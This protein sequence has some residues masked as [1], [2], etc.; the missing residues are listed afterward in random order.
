MNY[1]D[2]IIEREIVENEIK[3]IKQII[4]NESKYDLMSSQYKIEE[5]QIILN[6][7][8]EKLKSLY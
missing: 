4:A 2:L 8:E 7:L 3:N 1:S 6:H 5:Y